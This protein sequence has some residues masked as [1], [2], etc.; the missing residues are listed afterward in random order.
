MKTIKDYIN[1]N[2]RQ[3]V[4]TY[5]NEGLWDGIKNFWNWLTNNTNKHDY[6]KDGYYLPDIDYDNTV[7]R[8]FL[9]KK[10]NDKNKINDIYTTY[11]SKDNKLNKNC[12]EYKCKLPDV[13]NDKDANYELEHYIIFCKDKKNKNEKIIGMITLFQ[14]KDNTYVYKL[15]IIDWFLY[16][17]NDIF[18]EMI[19][20]VSINNNIIF[21]KEKSNKFNFLEHQ[22]Y[23]YNDKEKMYKKTYN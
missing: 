19:N 22:K 16:S 12:K 20:K 6:D 17:I 7:K 11:F 3:S 4:S 2:N 10:L 14:H 8:T 23:G 21:I 9:F 13:Y 5:V 1:E 18:D 15:T